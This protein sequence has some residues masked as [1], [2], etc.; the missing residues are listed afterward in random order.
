M[1]T[2]ALNRKKCTIGIELN[3]VNEDNYGVPSMVDQSCSLPGSFEACEEVFTD[4]FAVFTNV[5]N[6]FF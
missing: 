5:S 1:F 2:R 6:N 4:L 3:M